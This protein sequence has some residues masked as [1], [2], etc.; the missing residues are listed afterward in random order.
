M[1][2]LDRFGEPI[3]YCAAPGCTNRGV[4]Y[5]EIVIPPLGYPASRGLRTVV[6]LIL[7]RKHGQEEKAENF[8]TDRFREMCS[9]MVRPSPIP[10]DFDKATIRLGI[11]GDKRWK[12][13]EGQAG[14]AQAARRAN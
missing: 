4:V 12:A 7:C 2:L 11:V 14:Q 13:A 10:L 1:A 6:R 8:M 3:H 5:P 9:A